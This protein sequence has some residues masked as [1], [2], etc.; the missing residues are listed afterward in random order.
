[1]VESKIKSD[2]EES[3]DEK[4]S[5]FG[6]SEDEMD[7]EMMDSDLSVFE[8]SEDEMDTEKMESEMKNLKQENEELEKAQEKVLEF[9][10]NST[11]KVSSL[12]TVI[13]KLNK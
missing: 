1:M 12:N 8:Q 7:K 6:K 4:L 13:Q 5:V 11:L 3:N 10:S 9:L 2:T